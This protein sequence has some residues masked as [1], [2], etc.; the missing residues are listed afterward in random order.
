M[1]ARRRPVAALL[2]ALLVWLTAIGSAHVSLPRELQFTAG[3]ESIP[4]VSV[5]VP[6]A[7]FVA[8]RDSTRIPAAPHVTPDALPSKIVDSGT[9][10]AVARDSRATH[11][12]VRQA[13][14]IAAPYDA[15]APP[16]AGF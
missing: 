4:S 13:Q 8:T 5:A 10:P 7:T 14:G 16:A 15:T 6:R 11:S 12:R 3:S 2:A 9:L 1:V